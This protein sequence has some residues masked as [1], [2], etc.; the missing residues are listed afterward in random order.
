MMTMLLRDT[1]GRPQ[2]PVVWGDREDHFLRIWAGGLIAAWAGGP[3]A[4][5]TEFRDS[6]Q[7]LDLAVLGHETA[8]N[9]DGQLRTVRRAVGWAMY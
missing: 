3:V 1:R 6:P 8:M 7:Q 9:K 4:T 2:L 5:A